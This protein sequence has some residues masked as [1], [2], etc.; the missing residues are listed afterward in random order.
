MPARPSLD[1]SV[2]AQG[3]VG[4]WGCTLGNGTAVY[5]HATSGAV[6]PGKGWVVIELRG[7][8]SPANNPVGM[9]CV[10]YGSVNRSGSH[11]G[12]SV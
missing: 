10:D 7:L 9:H 11:G 3:G 6:S 1:A 12:R 4:S 8:V 5:Q 2:R